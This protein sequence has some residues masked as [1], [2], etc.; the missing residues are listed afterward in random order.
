M[1]K[2]VKIEDAFILLIINSIKYNIRRI[3]YQLNSI[4]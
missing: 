3:I 1:D 4:I 2:I